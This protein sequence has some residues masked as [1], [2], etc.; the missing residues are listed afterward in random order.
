MV[1]TTHS[2]T[3]DHLSGQRGTSSLGGQANGLREGEEVRRRVLLVTAICVVLIGAALFLVGA[4]K[5]AAG[6]GDVRLAGTAR[7]DTMFG[8]SGV[9]LVVGRGGDDHLYG[10][11]DPDGL[12]GG[13]GDDFLDT[14]GI[15]G[16]A[17]GGPGVES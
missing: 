17:T 14:G 15:G 4:P 13:A 16:T 2:V 11:A 5:I 8:D 6:G 9:D 1:F 7:S 3:K 10:G 12:L